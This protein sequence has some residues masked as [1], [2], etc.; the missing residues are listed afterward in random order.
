MLLDQLLEFC[1]VD[2]RDPIPVGELLTR[3]AKPGCGHQ[4]ACRGVVI[5]HD[6]CQT[7]FRE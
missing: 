1:S 5:G 6:A 4:Y 3:A 2:Q 7:R